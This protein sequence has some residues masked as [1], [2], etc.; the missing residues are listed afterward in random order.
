[1]GY[2]ST[3]SEERVGRGSE[4]GAF[5]GFL[6]EAQD[7]DPGCRRGDADD[8][9]GGELGLQQPAA[10]HLEARVGADADQTTVGPGVLAPPSGDHQEARCKHGT[11]V[12]QFAA[13]SV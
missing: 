10:G 11:V 5:V 13:V 7:Q 1:M 12:Y 2:F 8:V 9:V 6:L 4:G 3:R